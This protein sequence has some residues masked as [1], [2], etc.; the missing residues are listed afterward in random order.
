MSQYLDFELIN[1]TN[2]EIKVK[3][4]YWCT[5]IARGISWNFDNIFRYTGDD[6]VKLDIDTL[7][8]YIESIHNGIEKY[9][10][11][12]QKEQESKKENTELLLKA[13]SQFAVD[14]IKEDIRINEESIQDWLDEIET[15]ESVECKLNF[16][17]DILN[18][19]TNEWELI[20]SNA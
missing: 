17:L 12:L 3:L 14:A 1:K 13:Q 11:N 15:W 18:E 2:P 16:I 7:K 20:Y 9:K 19:N 4:G 8:S 10:S 5:S 6:V